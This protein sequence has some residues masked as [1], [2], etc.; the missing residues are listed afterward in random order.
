MRKYIT[1]I[2]IAVVGLISCDKT[3]ITPDS[4]TSDTNQINT[5]LLVEKWWKNVDPAYTSF[6]LKTNKVFLTRNDDKSNEKESGTWSI[7]NDT[8]IFQYTSG[9]SPKYKV[10]SVSDDN[11]SMNHTTIDMLYNFTLEN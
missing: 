3:T 8:L 5:T 7:T 4:T 1:I 2:S 11:L 6:F 10:I 9:S